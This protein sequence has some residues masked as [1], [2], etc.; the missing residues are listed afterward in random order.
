MRD[1]RRLWVPTRMSY[2][3]IAYNTRL[4][5]AATA[6]KTYE[7]LL[8]PKWKGKMVWP[9]L[10]HV[11][12]P[13]FVTNLRLTWGEDKAMAY[14]EAAAHAEHRQFRRRQSAHAGRPGDRGRISDRD[15][16]LRPSSADQ[17]RQG[18]AGHGAAPAA[19]R[20]RVRNAGH[21]QGLAQS[22][23][24]AAADGLPAVQGRAADSRRVRNICRSAPDVEPLAQIAPIVPARAGVQENFV[25]P[26]NLNSHTESSSKIV[27]DLFR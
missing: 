6:P 3:G 9:A 26:E 11:G 10:T 25:T 15:P 27:E 2:F 14:L 4:V 24:R 12:A 20:E 18:R 7:D 23:C 21:P 5:P 19:G 17:R 1:P 16:D 22:A 13:L 8:D